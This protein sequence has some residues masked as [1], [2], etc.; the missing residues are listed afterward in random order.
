[1]MASVR[2]ISRVLSSVSL[3]RCSS[4]V[5]ARWRACQTMLR[6]LRGVRPLGEGIHGNQPARVY[7]AFLAVEDLELGGWELQV[8]F[9]DL[10]PA[11]DCHPGVGF[12]GLGQVGL[13]EPYHPDVP[14]LVA[15]H[16]LGGLE[17]SPEAGLPGLPHGGHY[18]LLLPWLQL[19]D[20]VYLGEVVVT[21]GKQ[22]EQVPD[23]GDS[24]PPQPG[25]C[26]GIHPLE[27]LHRGVH[28]EASNG[29]PVWGVASRMGP[30]LLERQDY[31]AGLLAPG[32]RGATVGP[33]SLASQ[34]PIHSRLWPG[35][36]PW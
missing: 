3:G 31:P 20:L 2:G 27:T 7:Q 16:G 18:G 10:H 15:H 6:S 4:M 32:E 34:R 19:G 23:G 33:S 28:G 35:L 21:P 29:G 17:S 5:G 8:A 36:M 26:L 22:V 1:M 30:W 13:A 24:Q 14:R 9:V 12:E 25:G 11:A